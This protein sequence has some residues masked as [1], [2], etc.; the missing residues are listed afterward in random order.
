MKNVVINVL[1]QKLAE[2]LSDAVAQDET[3]NEFR[4]ISITAPEDMPANI[5]AK[6]E[7]ILRL[8]FHDIEAGDTQYLVACDSDDAAKIINFATDIY[9]QA[10]RLSPTPQDKQ[11]APHAYGTHGIEDRSVLHLIIH[12]Q[13]GI[14]RSAGVA[15]ALSD[16][17]GWEVVDWYGSP[18]NV[19]TSGVYTPN[20][21][22][23]KEVMEGFGMFPTQ[24]ELEKLWGAVL[25][26][27]VDG[28]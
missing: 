5:N 25:E 3:S 26:N 6:E 22:C 17:L 28:E 12:C 19:F 14:S 8:S 9:N 13:A 11:A 20:M 10:K 1:S 7:N 23:Y 18:E 27:T 24:E 21:T 16:A 2:Q 15:G 4:F